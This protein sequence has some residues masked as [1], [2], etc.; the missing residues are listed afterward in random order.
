MPKLNRTVIHIGMPK[1]GSTAIQN[2]LAINRESLYALDIYYPV[3]ATR[4]NAH[5][6]LAWAASLHRKPRVDIAPLP[7]TFESLSRELGGKEGSA[8]LSSEALFHLPRQE[9]KLIFEWSAEIAD[10]TIVVVY[11]RAPAAHHEG[12][13]KQLV[14]TSGYALTFDEHLREA[15]VI[16]TA[17]RLLAAEELLGRHR[18]N[19]RPYL[20]NAFR[21]RDVVNDFCE[22]V[23]ID[24]RQLH[25]IQ[26]SHTNPSLDVEL[27]E[28]K[29][30]L[31]RSGV[32][33]SHRLANALLEWTKRREP[34]RRSLFTPAS[35]EEFI[36]A[37]EREHLAVISRYHLPSA[38]IDQRPEDFTQTPLSEERLLELLEQ[39]EAE[40]PVVARECLSPILLP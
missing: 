7:E 28:F 26:H 14:K 8:V 5:H 36:G 21:D 40:F 1:T 19:V 24:S 22:V 10:S 34:S 38:L 4:G 6:P 20:P 32:E 37:T 29:T 3:S 17:S 13:Y 25:P 39:F 12:W 18:L 31:H 15:T 23:G 33:H 27:V 11:V 16:N 35:W 30:R 2:T 9:L